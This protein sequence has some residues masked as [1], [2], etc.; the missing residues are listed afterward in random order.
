MKVAYYPG[1]SVHGLAREYGQ[2][3]RLVCD[4]L[5][6]TLDEIEDWNCCG[7]SAAHSID[8][9]LAIGLGARNLALAE[10][11]G[12]SRVVTPC[13]GCF[14]RL[15]AASDSLGRSEVFDAGIER[16][17]A[18]PLPSRIEVLH[19]LQL[20]VETIGLNRVAAEVKRPLEGLKLC[21]YYGCLLTRPTQVTRFD[22]PEQPTSIDRLLSALG[23]DT[24]VWSHK[25]E[26]CGA[27][28]AASQTDIVL[29]LGGQVIEAACEAGAQAIV[30]A[31]PLCQANLDT[32]QRG[33]E[34]HLGKEFGIPIVYFTQMM[35]L[36]F[37]FS[38]A[39][40]GMKRSLVDPYPALRTWGFR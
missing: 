29:E 19:L 17:L 18:G 33:I 35:G 11:M 4:R 23:A 8:H 9:T 2:S 5:G 38:S 14:S 22:D 40:L 34:L 24:L 15:K 37:G 16:R 7:A 27:G 6:I 31:C 10:K 13:A 26:C 32:R 30:V 36:A 21:A 3:I 39:A 1:C 12:A 20:I 25:A 28:F